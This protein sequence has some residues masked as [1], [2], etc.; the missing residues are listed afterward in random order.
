M[1][2]AATSTVLEDSQDVIQPTV[3]ENGAGMRVELLDFGATIRSIRV[4]TPAGQLETVLSH[5]NLDDYFTNHHY[6][7]TTVGRY[8]NRLADSRA[9]IH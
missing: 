1:T 5:D 7:G 6:L 4:P 8:A 2:R 3:L 9:K